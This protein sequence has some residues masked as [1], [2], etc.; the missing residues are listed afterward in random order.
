MIGR[1]VAN[2]EKYVLTTLHFL[3]PLTILI[4]FLNKAWLVGADLLFVWIC[5]GFIGQSIHKDKTPGEMARGGLTDESNIR[6]SSDRVRDAGELAKPILH[7]SFLTGITVAV[8]LFHYG[9][10]WFFSVPMGFIVVIVLPVL[11]GVLFLRP[12]K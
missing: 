2:F 11:F 1:P 4:Y 10:R 9:Y 8:L 12:K 5:V 7:I 6:Q 3:L